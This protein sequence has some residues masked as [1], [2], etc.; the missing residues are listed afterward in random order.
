MGRYR[1]SIQLEVDIDVDQFRPDLEYART[2]SDLDAGS[3]SS[4]LTMADDFEALRTVLTRDGYRAV[5]DYLRG[6]NGVDYMSM[7]GE[8]QLE[9]VDDDRPL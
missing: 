1:L 6:F 5:S 4:V 2:Q 9:R 7:R 8:S 3:E